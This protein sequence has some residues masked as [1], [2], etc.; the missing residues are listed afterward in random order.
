MPDLSID[1]ITPKGLTLVGTRLPEN[2]AT[3]QIIGELVNLLNLER[4]S[5]GR[6]VEYSLVMVN[7]G[8]TLKNGQTLREMGVQD[9]DAIRIV[10][11]VPPSNEELESPLP[12]PPRGDKINVV[13]K[14]L[15]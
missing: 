8:V 11:S 9:G 3:E 7:Q 2:Y 6:P 5:N 1:L 10:G 12:E 13:I 15:D 14:V 4:L